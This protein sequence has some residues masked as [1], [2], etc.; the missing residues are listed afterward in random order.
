M[1]GQNMIEMTFPPR[2]LSHRPSE[3]VTRTV[4]IQARGMCVSVCVCVLRFRVFWQSLYCTYMF[5]TA[6][7]EQMLD[8]E[9]ASSQ[10][11][12]SSETLA[13]KSR[14][15]DSFYVKGNTLG[16]GRFAIVKAATHRTSGKE[17][18]VK[19][20]NRA[21]VF[22][23]EDI[24]ENELKIIKSVN[25]PNIIKLIED[26]ET[27]DEINLVMELLQVLCVCVRACVRMYVCT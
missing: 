1:S 11:T 10:Y 16:E 17:Y 8:S 13:D 25:H 12:I 7:T 18:A 23:R 5:V 4:G 20:I 14:G 3:R 26:F 21:K 19:T 2:H 22:S 6:A 15:L 24:I 9:L 27:P